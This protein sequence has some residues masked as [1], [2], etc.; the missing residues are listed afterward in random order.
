MKF[1]YFLFLFLLRQ[2]L[3]TYLV[4]GACTC[5]PD[6]L[7]SARWTILVDSFKE[8]LKHKISLEKLAWNLEC[9]A[10]L[11]SSQACNSFLFVCF[12]FLKSI[13]ARS[14]QELKTFGPL[15]H[16]WIV[17]DF[18]KT[19]ASSKMLISICFSWIMN[20]YL[21]TTHLQ[22]PLWGMKWTTCQSN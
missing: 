11:H 1:I 17:K 2:V 10:L 22:L 16:T 5:H 18:L 4:S 15:W 21:F 14:S 6:C 20:H 9:M 8:L 7:Q 13:P 12:V 19:Q 3:I